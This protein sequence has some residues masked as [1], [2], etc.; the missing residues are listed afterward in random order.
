MGSRA[1]LDGE[2]KCRRPPGF[3]PPWKLSLFRKLGGRDS[4]A[5]KS[6]LAAIEGAIGA[7]YVV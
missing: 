7:I 3:D 6:S 4:H 1:G 5:W 2:A